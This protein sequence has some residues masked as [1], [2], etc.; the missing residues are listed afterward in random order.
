MAG[1]AA[2]VA[3]CRKEM[4]G[5]T[6][7]QGQVGAGSGRAAV[8]AFW[9]SRHASKTSGLPVSGSGRI[10]STME[11][12]LGVGRGSSSANGQTCSSC[13]RERLAQS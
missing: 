4:V 9:A 12:T 5:L 8:L 2:V 10:S 13:Q 11:L 7:R 3:S 6:H 1:A